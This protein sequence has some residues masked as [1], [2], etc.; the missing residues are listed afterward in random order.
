MDVV[1]RTR[2]ILGLDQL[3]LTGEGQS[4]EDAELLAGKYLTEKVYLEAERGITPM[5]GKVS[6]EIQLTPNISAVTEIWE[7]SAGGI[8]L[9]WKWDY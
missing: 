6:L 8:G 4:A 9:N 1:G 3:T 7:N 2:E 5:S